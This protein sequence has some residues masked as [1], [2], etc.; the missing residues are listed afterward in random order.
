[1]EWRGLDS[2][3]SGQEQAVGSFEQANE[4]TGYIPHEEFFEQL[5]IS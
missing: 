4:P 2:S 5:R 3:G 1:M